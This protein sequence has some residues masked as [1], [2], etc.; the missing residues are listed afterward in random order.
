MKRKLFTPEQIVA[1][2]QQA[3]AGTTSISEVCRQ[4]GITEV[5]F[6]RWRRR[7]QGMTVNDAKELKRLADENT[8]LKK[9]LAERD[10]E[11]DA[12]KAVLGKKA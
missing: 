1:I 8:R 10:L 7:Y 6:Y 12:L 11:V 9:L 2:L 4:H 3:E 5:T